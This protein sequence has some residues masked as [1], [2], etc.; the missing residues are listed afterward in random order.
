MKI[1]F[2]DIQDN[3]SMTI[4]SVERVCERQNIKSK[5][6]AMRKIQKALERGSGA[7]CFQSWERKY[8]EEKKKGNCS[9]IAYDQYCY[10]VSEDGIC[11]TVFSLPKYFG[12][13]KHFDGKEKIRNVKKYEKFK[14][15]ALEIA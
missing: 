13:R 7:E 6:K 11:V 8:M 4:H 10:I 14:V 2:F 12:K 15:P 9:P 1:T 3:P 5:A